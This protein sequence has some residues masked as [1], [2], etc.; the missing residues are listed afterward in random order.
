MS[1]ISEKPS[2][3][4]TSPPATP[5][6]PGKR[7]LGWAVLAVVVVG[8]AGYGAFR[9]SRGSSHPAAGIAPRFDAPS[10]W[11]AEKARSP[12]AGIYTNGSGDAVTIAGMADEE[13]KG[14]ECDRLVAGMLR[15][16]ARKAGLSEP[17]AAKALPSTDEA[18]CRF[19]A[20]IPGRNQLV[21]G[22]YML[23]PATSSGIL[24]AYFRGLDATDDSGIMNRI[25]CPS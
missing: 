4:K 2:K 16:M 3:S 21:S 18:V 13:G 25:H 20:E 5:T 17:P 19:S 7:P 24:F 12:N 22:G 23:C 6:R 10:G 15:G 14:P 11:H 1:P 9:W 8:L